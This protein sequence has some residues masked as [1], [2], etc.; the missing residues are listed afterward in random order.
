[1]QSF[2]SVGASTARTRSVV[3]P[4][5]ASAVNAV[6]GRR[7][8]QSSRTFAP[9]FLVL[10]LDRVARPAPV[11]VRPASERGIEIAAGGQRLAAVERDRLAI[12]PTAGVRHQEYGE[13]LQLLQRSNPSHRVDLGGALARRIAG[14]QSLAHALG[15]DLARRDGVEADAVASPF[16]RERL[17]HHGDRPLAHRGRYDEGAAVAYPG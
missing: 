12:D 3:G 1:M 16:G 9:I 8:G 10:R 7:T 17:G 14:I 2:A 11:V 4:S 6:P 5:P 15:R 13:V